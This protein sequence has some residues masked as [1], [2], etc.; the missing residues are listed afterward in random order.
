EVHRKESLLQTAGHHG[1]QDERALYRRVKKPHHCRPGTLALRESHPYLKSTELLIP[2]LPLQR[3]VRE[4]AQDF[5]TGL[6]FQS[7]AI[8]ALW[9][10]RKA[11]LEGLSED[12]NVCAIESPSCPKTSS[13]LAG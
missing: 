8:G 6:R 13:W 10:A 5:K 4:I 2:K 7:A 3:L 1:G 9:E 12:T 11:D